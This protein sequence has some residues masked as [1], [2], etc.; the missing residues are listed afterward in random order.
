MP[1]LTPEAERVLAPL[2]RRA[3]LFGPYFWLEFAACVG[4]ALVIEAATGSF[5]L[6]MAWLLPVVVLVDSTEAD[7][8]H[9]VER[10]MNE[11][12]AIELRQA[13]EDARQERS[14]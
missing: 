13:F 11:L 1:H 14:A 12:R 3:A 4:S 5:W 10:C 2:I 7:R 9:A 6:A 8:E